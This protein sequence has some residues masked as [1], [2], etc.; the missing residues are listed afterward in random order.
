MNNRYIA[1]EIRRGRRM[2]RTLSKEAFEISTA[3]YKDDG[4]ARV[5]N[6]E[7]KT[8]RA[9]IFDVIPSVGKRMGYRRGGI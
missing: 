3:G 8:Y 6:K 9:S 4:R 7:R 5:R 1:V 2:R